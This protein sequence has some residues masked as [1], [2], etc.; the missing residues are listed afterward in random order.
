M[1]KI[2]WTDLPPALR[3]HLFDRLRDRK[4]T[5]EEL[6]GQ[7][8]GRIYFLGIGDSRKNRS[9][10]FSWLVPFRLASPLCGEDGLEASLDQAGAAQSEVFR[11]GIRA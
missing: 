2:Q 1:P 6:Y 11:K 10:P 7:E 9:V 4:I 8:R 3:N 5:V